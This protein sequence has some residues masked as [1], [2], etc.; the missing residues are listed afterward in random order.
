MASIIKVDTIQDQSG[1]NIIN[2]NANTITIGASGDTITIPSGATITGFKSTGIVDNATAN[3][4]TI[5]SDETVTVVKKLVVDTNTLVVD[6]TNNRVGIGTSN[7][8]SKLEISDSIPVRFNLRNTGLDNNGEIVSFQW[9]NDADFTIQGRDSNEVFKANWYTITSTATD[10]YA[11]EHI[12]YTGSSAERMRIDSSGHVLVGTTDPLAGVSSSSGKG[13]ALRSEGY[14]FASIP[15]DAPLTIN[16]QTSDGNIAQFRK[17]GTTVGSIRSEGGDIVFGNDTRGL[18][19]RDTDIIPRDMDNTTS[20]NQVTLGSTGSRFADIYLGGGAYIGGTGTANKL[21]DYEEGTWTPDFATGYSSKTYSDRR[22]HYTKIGR[23]VELKFYLNV[24]S[25]TASGNLTIT[26]LPFTSA[27]NS[28]NNNLGFIHVQS[29]SGTLQTNSPICRMAVN[30]TTIYV[31]TQG[32][33]SINSMAGSE[34]GNGIING[35]II[36]YV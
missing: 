10:G 24:T 5:G 19:Y 28:I 33:T 6:N 13:I 14:I 3:A 16:R 27:N 9:N 7:P 29:N 1:N 12:W 4:I 11:D 2:E 15:N 22:G 34:L 30:S 35:S 36:Y 32:T 18:K 25:T 8:L 26:G 17:D 23:M 21:D 20:D 31:Q